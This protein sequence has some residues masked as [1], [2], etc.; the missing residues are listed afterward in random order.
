MG[1]WLGG[2]KL[3]LKPGLYLARIC[4]SLGWADAA[5]REAFWAWLLAGIY[6]GGLWLALLRWLEG[7]YF[8]SLKPLSMDRLDSFSRAGHPTGFMQGLPGI[9]HWLL[10]KRYPPFTGWFRSDP[11]GSRWAIAIRAR[12]GSRPLDRFGPCWQVPFPAQGLAD[13]NP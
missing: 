12:Q 7:L 11:R 5:N 13:I 4:V 3:K 8:I 10:A 1:R 6:L 9:I 2:L